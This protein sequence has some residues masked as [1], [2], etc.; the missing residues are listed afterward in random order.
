M[1]EF[2]IPAETPAAEQLK[3]RSLDRFSRRNLLK[4]LERLER[5]RLVIADGAE[6]VAFG[7]TSEAFPLEAVITVHHQRFYGDCL[8]RGTIGAGE[9]YMMGLWSTD[10]LTA[11]VR[12]F[13]LHPEVFS[14]MDTGIAR[15]T[16]PLL[17][18]L[19]A[20]NKNTREGSRRNIVAHYDLGN[21]F[22][23][24]FLDETLTYSCGIFERPESTLA[25]ASAA[26]YERICRK[27]ALSASDH[28]LEIGT[29]WGGFALHAVR[30][31]GCRVTTTTISDRQHELAGRRIA[32]AGLSERIRLLKQDYRD[33]T[34]SYDKLVSIEMIEAVGHQFLEEFFRVC[35]QRLKPDGAMLL[36]AITIRD[37]VFDWHKK[38]VDFIK[39][40]IFPGS[41]I[42]SVAVICDA[43]ARA[44][45]LRLFHLE[46][47]TPHYAVTLRHWRENFFRNL[48]QVKALGFSETFI[49]MWEFYLCYCEGGFAERYLGDVQML[50][51]KPMCR[52]Q[53]IL[54]PVAA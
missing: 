6:R 4:L 31:F 20:L 51:T 43:V 16:A 9:A 41:C 5:G 27:L 30:R 42:P 54:P 35:S 2:I 7:R 10:D 14:G 21:D 34:G 26:K 47:I 17:K 37:Q 48:G 15:I 24:L 44:T 28:V 29:G 33:L 25:E 13:A 52:R 3:T 50:F 46:D 19:H 36:Q 23:R 1:T 53:P 11:V 38:N 45:D 18:Y 39:R 32:E 12:I 40:Y 49:R 22:Y 8:F